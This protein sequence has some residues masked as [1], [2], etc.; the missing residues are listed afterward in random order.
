MLLFAIYLLLIPNEYSYEAPDLFHS[1]ENAPLFTFLLW[2]QS[3]INVG[4]MEENLI[5]VR[6]SGDFEKYE[7][8]KT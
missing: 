7:Y 5:L 8:E 6:R 2:T 4:Y 3:A 1:S